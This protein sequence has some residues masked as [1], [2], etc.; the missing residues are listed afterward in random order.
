[1]AHVAP[2]GTLVNTVVSPWPTGTNALAEWNNL[3][4]CFV[5][6]GQPQ[7]AGDHARRLWKAEILTRVAEMVDRGELRAHVDR[8]VSFNSV[9]AAHDALEAGETL[10]RVVLNVA[11]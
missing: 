11:A 1:L 9:G 4:I 6:I 2:F 3:D 10:G 5:N 8:I 7:I